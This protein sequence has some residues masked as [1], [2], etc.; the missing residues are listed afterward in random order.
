[1]RYRFARAARLREPADFANLTREAQFRA[2]GRWLALSARFEQRGGAV[3]LVRFGFTIGRRYARRAVD[4]TLVKRVLR[5]AARHALPQLGAVARHRVD[6]LLRVTASL[7]PG[8]R[9]T[10]KR[11]LRAE[12]DALLTRLHVQLVHESER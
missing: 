2:H 10:V 12:A 3:A 7:P 8:S 11:L 1:M 5:E 4:R 6:V 9:R